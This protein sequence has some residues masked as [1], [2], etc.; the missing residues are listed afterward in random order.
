M[1]IVPAILAQEFEE[2]EE[3]V[4]MMEGVIPLSSK[5]TDVAQWVSLDIVDG[6]FAKPTSWPYT[7][8][9]NLDVVSRL[10]EL[11]T[12]LNI[13]LHL[14]VKNPEHDLDR[15]IDTPAKRILVH[16][17]A[18][19]N[20]DQ[21]LALLDMSTEECGLVLN[22]DTPVLAIEPYLQYLDF[23]QLMRIAQ[24][25]SYG[26]PFEERVLGKVA[27]LRK[28][29]P[30]LRIQL[31]G[32]VNEKNIA[33]IKAAGVHSVAIGSA[34]FKTDDPVVTFNKLQDMVS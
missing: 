22:L 9:D 12:S 1:E 33:K 27:E 20:H 31:D 17:E 30:K 4:R 18:A 34:I 16:Y 15:F 3:K 25:G 24:I 23:I 7:Y 2:I 21:A 6:E 5:T 28:H 13:E 14:M 8:G 19:D 32:G 10:K 26:A 29:H 11:D